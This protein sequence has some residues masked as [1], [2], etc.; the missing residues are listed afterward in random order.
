MVT[1]K[2]VSSSTGKPVSGKRV[3]VGFQGLTRGM[4]DEG[5]TDSNGEVHFNNDPGSGK[6]FVDHKT[7]FEGRIEGRVV[8]YV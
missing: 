7:A 5:F 3:R 2:V 1:I 6:V 4:S 8:V